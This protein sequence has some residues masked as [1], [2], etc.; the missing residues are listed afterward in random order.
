V[1]K[2]KNVGLGADN[3][4]LRLLVLLAGIV[5]EVDCVDEFFDETDDHGDHG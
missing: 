1:S 5:A 4:S 3:E 2:K